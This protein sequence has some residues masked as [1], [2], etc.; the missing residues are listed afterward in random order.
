M[1]N[2]VKE[3][4]AFAFLMGIVTTGLVSLTVILVNL[5]FTEAFWRIWLK[6]WSVAYLVI[7][8]LILIVSPL[9]QRFVGY[10][11]NERKKA[12]AWEASKS[13]NIEAE[14]SQEGGH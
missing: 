1:K 7:V 13:A 14:I 2:N 10:L 3:K 4:L 11:F 5:G 12:G 6:S 8:P 9:I